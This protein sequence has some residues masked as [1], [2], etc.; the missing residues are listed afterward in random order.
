MK[1]Y[2]GTR[3][4][5]APTSKLRKPASPRYTFSEFNVSHLLIVFSKL[6]EK[7]AALQGDHA[8][9]KQEYENQQSER[10]RIR[11][12]CLLQVLFTCH[13]TVIAQPS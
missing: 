11:Y 7:L 5:C 12:F 6:E 10:T 2:N 8:R 9:S 13:F 1:N 4:D 3:K